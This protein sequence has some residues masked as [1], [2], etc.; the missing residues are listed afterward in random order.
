MM[1]VRPDLF[2]PVGRDG[3]G[4]NP[5]ASMIF[6]C[7][8]MA[9][10]GQVHHSNKAQ[11]SSA[12]APTGS[13]AMSSSGLRAVVGFRR[14]IFA[15]FGP[16]RDRSMPGRRRM[17]RET[18]AGIG[19]RDEVVD[20]AAVLDDFAVALFAARDVTFLDETLRD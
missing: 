11:S 1:V 4:R 13:P 9:M 8:P 10:C 7:E 16:G 6:T 17:T 3:R 12:S 18:L 14:A 20:G 19:E 5:Q 15:V 2:D